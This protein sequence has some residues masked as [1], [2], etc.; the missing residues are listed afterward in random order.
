MEEPVTSSLVSD[1]DGDEG[2]ET[3]GSA[4][5]II[6]FVVA[7]AILSYAKDI[8]LPLAIAALL[9]VVF[10]PTAS[11]LERLV[12]RFVSAA[13][14]VVAV[15]SSLAALGYFLTIELTSVA[16]KMTEYSDN[17][18]AKLANL[19]GSTPEWLQ[20]IESGV[21]DVQL[22]VQNAGPRLPKVKA[23]EIVQAQLE[24]STAGDVLK[25]AWPILAGIAEGLLIIVLFFFLLYG[26]RD[27]RDRLIRL[28][29]R[30]RVPVAAQAIETAGYIVGHYL[31]L[32]TLT[33]LG[34]GL[35]IG[36]VVWLLGLPNPAF[37][38]GLAFLL[39]FIPYVGVLISAA[40][41]TL[42]AV[43]VFPGWSRSL[44]VAGSF[45]VLDQV[46]A[47]FVE[48]FVIGHGIGL[49]PLALLVSAMFWA[50]LWGLPGLL[51]ATPLT[52]CLKVAGD[53]IPGLGVMSILLGA[54]RKL[55][56]YHD[57]YRTLL[58]LDQAAARTRAIR[59]CDENGLEQTFNDILIPAV[60]LSGEER[61]ESHISRENEKFIIETT[62][63]LVSEL[64][65]RFT[66][67]RTAPRLRI[68]G[69]CAPG[70]VHSLGLLILLELF[71]H[72]GAAATLM[73]PSKTAE[74][75]RQFAARFQPDMV[76]LSCTVTECLPA[77]LELTHGLK[78]DSPRLTIIGGGRAALSESSE[79]LQAGCSRV[80]GSRS[81][82]RRAIR[83]YVLRR[84][85]SRTGL[86]EAPRPLTV[87]ESAALKEPDPISSTSS[88][89]AV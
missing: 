86:P 23:P 30:V 88:P 61:A 66:K 2:P 89:P 41:P 24:A 35:A 33:N 60:I 62:R 16:V 72:E 56:D 70:D 64:G 8:L 52:A 3:G 58:E 67:P 55:E 14:I 38:G 25:P 59:Y 83:R 1:D 76:C 75:I 68:L 77:A 65:N 47:Q 71:R 12:G 31:L 21:K 81:E 19:E 39:R 84:I 7:I 26:R 80:C 15:I 74:E 45:I 36:I 17:I 63:E 10:S 87:K 57:Y 46:A 48:P 5:A 27:L 4:K 11:H 44:E 79:L 82:A 51:M 18:A 42:V 43:A 50:W 6:T 13:L 9:A 49:S 22:Q 69:I 78:Q 29:A 34:Y 40:L 54:D 32:F 37:W 20:R 28:A 53:F 73:D 85:R